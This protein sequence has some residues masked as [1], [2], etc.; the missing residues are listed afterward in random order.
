MTSLAVTPGLERSL[1]ASPRGSSAAAAGGT[2]W[3]G[4]ARPRWCRCRRPARRR[5]RA[6]RCGCRRRPRSSPGCVTPSSGPMTCTIPCPSLPRPCSSMPKSWRSSSPAPDLGRGLASRMRTAPSRPRGEV[7]DR[8]IHGGDGPLRTAHL[9]AALAQ[10]GE[11]LRRGHLVDQVQVDV[12][13]GRRV[14][15]SRAHRCASQTSR[16]SCAASC[17]SGITGV[18]ISAR[19]SLSAPG[20]DLSECRFMTSRKGSGAAFDDI[21]GDSARPRYDAGAAVLR[22]SRS[23]PSPWAS[24]PV[25][26]LASSR[27]PEASTREA[28]RLVDR[29]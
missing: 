28:G 2:G 26:T 15:V 20:D 12:E 6:W 7:G 1:D 9:Q 24:S 18:P 10:R 3:P 17:A 23:S 25:E 16:T 27:S 22:T 14:G 13:N 5:R 19:A 8:V 21:G 11:G 4:R 29:L